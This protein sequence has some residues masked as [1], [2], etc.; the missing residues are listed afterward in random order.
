MPI[1]EY[2]GVTLDG[3]NAYAGLGASSMVG[4]IYYVGDPADLTISFELIEIDT[5]KLVTTADVMI[6]PVSGGNLDAHADLVDSS[7]EAIPTNGSNGD[8][9]ADAVQAYLDA[10]PLADFGF[11]GWVGPEPHGAN[12]ADSGMVRDPIYADRAVAWLQDRF[13]RRLA[14]DEAAKRPFLLVVSFVNPHDIVF[15][16]LWLG[17]IGPSAPTG[18]PEVPPVPASPTD[19]EDLSSKPAAATPLRRPAELRWDPM[20]HPASRLRHRHCGAKRPT[21]LLRR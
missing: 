8:L 13:A 3:A 2:K 20:P 21:H 11:P 6:K 14:G 19:D 5:D 4:N 10:D 16:P 15:A 9:F 7:G 18:L 12:R 1:Y 17:R